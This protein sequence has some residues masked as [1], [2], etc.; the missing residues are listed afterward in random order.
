MDA[1]TAVM[2]VAALRTELLFI[3]GPKASLG[4][5][6]KAHDRL[7]I[8]LDR[9]PPKA[10][11]VLGYAGGVRADLSPG[12]LVLAD[13]V[14]D[15]EGPVGVSAELLAKAQKLLPGAKVGPIFTD[16]KL[17]TRGEKAQLEGKA[18]AV[19][20]ETSFV[21]RE[22][23]ARQIPFLVGRVILDARWEEVRGGWR[24]SLWAYRALRCSWVLARAAQAL[25]LALAEAP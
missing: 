22:L 16:H 10:V 7:Q 20:M 15:E 4:V 1:S 13:V 21:A 19:D 2:V 9:F 25:R 11:A 23:L 3:P 14:F 5:G 8:M 24:S 18:L 17:A 12:T 6:P